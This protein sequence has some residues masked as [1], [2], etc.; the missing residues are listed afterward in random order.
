[1][2]TNKFIYDFK[3]WLKTQ[4]EINENKNLIGN[5]VTT[6][7]SLKHFCEVADIV[8]GNPIKIGKDFIKN[9]GV[10]EQIIEN[11]ALIKSSKGKF[12]LKISDVMEN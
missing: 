4:N 11:Q 6:K 7:L 12:Y 10:V 1:M 8:V 2:N 5:T 9:G 3:K